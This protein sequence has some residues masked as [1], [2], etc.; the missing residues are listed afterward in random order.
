MGQ[1]QPDIHHHQEQYK[2]AETKQ[3]KNNRGTHNNS[4][5]LTVP[6]QSPGNDLKGAWWHSEDIST[7]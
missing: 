6:S 5:T 1:P 3:H 4:K 2:D 7:I